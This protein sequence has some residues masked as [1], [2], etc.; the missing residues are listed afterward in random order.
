L[1][2]RLRVSDQAVCTSGDYERG[3]HILNARPGAVASATVVAPNAM[4]A[5][6]LATAAFALGPV[7]GIAFL[8][9]MGVE[10]LI[11]TPDLQRFETPGVPHA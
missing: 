5:D 7:D 9:R 8:T 1:I 2:A 11:V 3:E 10:G 4:L 6:A